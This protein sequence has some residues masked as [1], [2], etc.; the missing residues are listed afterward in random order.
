M[1]HRLVGAGRVR[2][3]DGRDPLVEPH[4]RVDDHE[5]KA[6][7]QVPLELLARLLGEDD[8]GAVGHAVQAIEH[9]DLAIVLLPGRRQHDLEVALEQRLGRAVQDAREIRGI[10]ERDDDTDE[11]GAARRQATCAAV[12]RV[13]VLADDA[14]DVVARLVRDVAAAVQNTR[15]RG[16]RHTRL[17]GDLA[18]GRALG[19]GL[20]H[21]PLKHVP[22]RSGTQVRIFPTNLRKNHL[23]S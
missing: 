20:R 18:D 15:Y 17:V 22:E 13:A 6:A 14:A 1:A 8:Q 12:G 21:T 11:A 2:G 9:R 23:T 4:Q 5:P 16:D 7:V 10:D 3:R 19:G